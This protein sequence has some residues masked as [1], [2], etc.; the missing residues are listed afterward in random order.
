MRAPRARVP[1]A[2]FTSLGVGGPARFFIEASSEADIA[3]AVRLAR[4]RG[5]PL[6]P[7]GSG[8][9]ILVPDAGIEAVV[10][11]MRGDGFVFDADDAGALLVADAGASWDALVHRAAE[12]GLWGI[13]NL[14]GIPGSAGGALVQNIGAYG[15]ELSS[16][17]AYAEVFDASAGAMRRIAPAESRLAYR[18]SLYREHRD[19]V[20]MRIALAL[21]RSGAPGLGYADLARA[22]E[23][24][25]PLSSPGE[26]ADA[27][28]AI[29]A[30]K[31]P[32]KG[33]G[34]TAGSFFK[35][36]VIAA[37][38]AL[39]LKARFPGLPSYPES[40]GRVKL[41]LAW[42]LDRALGLKGY[43]RGAVRLYERQ[44]LV[45]VAA[46][47]ASAADIDAFARGIAARA[48]DELGIGIEREVET[49]GAE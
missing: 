17:F 41:S 11:A 32:G 22:K 5:L 48:Q 21:R 34:G 6:R 27:V 40:D 47:G 4:V 29:R 19:F 37:D 33:E 9:N 28:R 39:R 44:P 30:R 12:R 2:P 7:L 26:V 31:F 13:E 15:A 10:A 35:N 23:D 45:V 3:E 16:V 1:L 36:P 25:I 49:F 42:L 20:I 43:G 38:A 18:S 14:A 46:P 24:G 8:T